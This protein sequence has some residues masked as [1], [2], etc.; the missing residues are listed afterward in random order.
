MA[1]FFKYDTTSDSFSTP[2]KPSISI[3]QLEQGYFRLE[4]QNDCRSISDAA[5]S[6]R[7]FEVFTL[8][9]TLS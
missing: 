8:Q 3:R 5:S 6:Q 2:T 1:A 4:E 7:K 9:G